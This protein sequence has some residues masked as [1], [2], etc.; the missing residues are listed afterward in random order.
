MKKM[1]MSLALLLCLSLLAG[2]SSLPIAGLRGG[3]SSL[4]WDWDS[5]DDSDDTTYDDTDD[6]TYDDTD[7]TTYDDTDDTTNDDTDDT[8]YDDTAYDDAFDDESSDPVNAGAGMTVPGPGY[9]LQVDGEQIAEQYTF[10]DDPTI[11]NCMCYDL[12]NGEGDTADIIAYRMKMEHEGYEWYYDQR[13]EYDFYAMVGDE[14]TLYLEVYGLIPYEWRLYYPDGSAVLEGE[15][16]GSFQNPSYD[17][18]V[19]PDWDGRC[20]GC[21]GTGN[22][23]GCLG[24]GRLSYGDR[25]ECN[26][27]GGTGECNICDGTGWCE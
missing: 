18:T 27:C 8:T 2:C 19:D 17:I 14:V 16:S 5:D 10:G 20:P 3:T 15:G 13:E 9:F 24:T 25:E 23:Q 6:T 22:C 1:M 7:D 26:L 12:P 11:Y 21:E 4:G